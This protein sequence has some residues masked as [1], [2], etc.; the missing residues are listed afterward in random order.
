MARITRVTELPGP[1]SAAEELWYDLRRRPSF[2]DGFGHVVKVEG[3]W[4]DVGGRIVWNAP[5]NTRGV[6]A[7]KV[8]WY[9]ARTGQ[10]LYVEDEQLR[11]TQTVRFEP[12]GEGLVRVTLAFDWT[13]KEGNALT[14]WLFVRRRMGE[15]LRLTLV[16][17]RIER[18]ADLDDGRP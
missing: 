3:A 8:D 6:V 18:L 15:S 14:D 9:E 4:P 2:V 13:L 17:F 5:P 11:G 12:A 7:E 1:V 10:K 16:K